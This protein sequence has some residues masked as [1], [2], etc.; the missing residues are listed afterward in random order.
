MNGELIAAIIL[1]IALT[2]Y[3]WYEWKSEKEG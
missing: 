2:Y 1:V 3:F